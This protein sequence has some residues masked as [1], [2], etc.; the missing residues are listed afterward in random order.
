MNDLDAGAKALGIRLSG[1]QLSLFGRYQ[2]LLLEW[3][4]RINL[5]AVRDPILIQQRHFVD[6]LACYAATGDLNDS[7]LIDVGSGAGFPGLPL[8]IA[9]P[10]LKLTL[11][12]SV[13]KKA[14]FLQAVVDELKLDQ[15]KIIRER[16]ETTGHD[17]AHREVYDWAVARAVARL[18]VLAEYLLPL[19]RPGGYM[20]TLKGQQAQE[21]IDEAQ[22][23]IAIL[24][25]GPGRLLPVTVPGQEEPSRLV[26]IEKIQMTPEKYP[27]RVGIPGK[28]PL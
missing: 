9:F 17:Q 6:S 2:E 28:R 27:R 11:V 3:N 16:A 20:L 12:E 22:R 25:G 24:G 10:D 14:A 13:G 21:E 26:L 8:K 18:N 7:L 23:G 15:V 4:Q 19:V 1:K 5:T